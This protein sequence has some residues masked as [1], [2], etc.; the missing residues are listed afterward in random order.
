MIFNYF[1]CMKILVI[2]NYDSFT[3]NLIQQLG[4]FNSKIIVKRNDVID[5]DDVIKI[6][7]DKI[8]IS[9]GPK[10]P[11]DSRVSL[12]I[13]NELGP[14][15]PILG[16]CLGLQAIALVYGGKVVKAKH[17]VHGM[18]SEILHDNKTIFK[19]VPQNF[20]AMRYHSLIV[21]KNSLPNLLEITAQTED[22]I[23]MGIRHKTYPT[24][25]IQ[26]HPESILTEHG[27]K[28]ISNWLLS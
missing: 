15:I 10:R 19:N 28:I 12:D 8:L 23:I 22:G 3:Y 4:H 2:D 27:S 20:E 25:G 18:T 16:V 24:D 5:L 1:I 21:D 6:K 9:P 7:P 17:P 11:E 13:V 14:T 26:F